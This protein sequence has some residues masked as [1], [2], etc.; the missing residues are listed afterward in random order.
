MEIYE[1]L[2]NETDEKPESK[3]THSTVKL[4]NKPKKS[5]QIWKFD[6]QKIGIIIFLMRSNFHN[7]NVFFHGHFSVI[8]LEESV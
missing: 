6:W 5:I 1:I 2:E 7:I 4:W 3:Q 8:V